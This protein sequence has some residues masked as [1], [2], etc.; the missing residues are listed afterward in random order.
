MNLKRWIPLLYVIATAASGAA[1]L[2][3]APVEPKY[4][5][6]VAYYLSYDNDL[7][8]ATPIIVKAIR[9]GVNSPATV[10]AVQ[11]DL[12][13]PGG[14]HRIEITSKK[15]TS[16]NL[17]S[18]DSANEDEAIAYL[19][20][21]V[22]TY[23]CKHY[24]F[25]FLDHGGRLDEMCLDESPDTKDKLYMSGRTLG[26]KLRDFKKTIPAAS[27][28]DLLFFQQCGR[29]SLE[30]LYS[31][32]GTAEFILCSPVSVGAPNSYYTPLHQWLGDHAE[33]TGL[34]VAE[35][36]A[37]EDTDYRAYTCVKTRKLDEL[38][39]QLDAALKLPL[40]RNAATRLPRMTPA[41]Y[42]DSD[43][44]TRD[45]KLWFEAIAAA[46]VGTGGAIDA[47]Q[48]FIANDLIAGV[49]Y[50]KNADAETKSA[51][52]GLSLFV[53]DSAESARRYREMDLYNDSLLRKFWPAMFP[54][55]Q[56][57]ATAAK[58]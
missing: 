53:P 38:P 44:S 16:T 34:S 4:D 52:S 19:D 39:E 9:A 24:A 25:M 37:A 27:Q 42:A 12:P 14:M 57:S 33:A 23:P 11:V 1:D 55:P 8:K 54:Q 29:G 22:K 30:N 45:T 36:I 41:I 10:A 3:P 32:R 20:W 13:G 7:A 35:K 49:W 18:D 56:A 6:G 51:L 47:L 43:E 2:A 26:A 58:R 40:E 46:N 50:S 15:V 5:W 28:W 21:F 31:F 17:K 48:H